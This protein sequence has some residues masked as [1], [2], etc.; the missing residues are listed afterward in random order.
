[1]C[2]GKRNTQGIERKHLMF[3]TGF[4]RLARKTICCSKSLEM[5]KIMFGLLIN[6]LEFGRQPF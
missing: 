1:L 5:Y 2:T 4:K 6:V 3:R